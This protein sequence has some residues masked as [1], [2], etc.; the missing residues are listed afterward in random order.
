VFPNDELASCRIYCRDCLARLIDVLL[1]GGTD[2]VMMVRGVVGGPS[3]WRDQL[4]KLDFGD[5]GGS[6]WRCQYGDRARRLQEAVIELIG[7]T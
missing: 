2:R 6:K 3:N 7:T 1:V 4:G 5:G